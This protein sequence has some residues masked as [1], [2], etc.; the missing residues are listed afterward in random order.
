MQF[1]FVPPPFDEGLWWTVFDLLEKTVERGGYEWSEVR[2]DL[3]AGR[4]Q[5]WLAV[6]NEPV[7]AMVTRMDGDTL[8]VWLAGG[9]VLSGC[10]PFLEIALAAAKTSGATN[11]RIIGR[12]GWARV[13]HPFGWRRDGDELIKEPI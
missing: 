1:G 2:E 11:G 7:A 6:K 10:I 5:L 8:E 12:K 3:Y 13:L 9:A 4:A